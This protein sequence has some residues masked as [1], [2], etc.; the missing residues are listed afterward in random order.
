MGEV[1]RQPAILQRYPRVDEG[2]GS[3]VVIYK[4]RLR[5]RQK[6]TEANMLIDFQVTVP[7]TENT[8]IFFAFVN[9]SKLEVPTVHGSTSIK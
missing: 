7:K 5:D 9:H 8:L 3:A 6:R 1:A 2:R 4:E